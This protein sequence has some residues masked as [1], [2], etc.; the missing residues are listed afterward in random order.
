MHLVGF[1]IRIY[2][3]ARSPERQTQRT[4][5]VTRS[6]CRA[7]RRLTTVQICCTRGDVNSC[8]YPCNENQLN[9][10]FIL[11]LFRPSTS[12]GHICSPSSG[13]KL[14]IYSNW[15]VLCFSVDCLLDGLEWILKS[16][17]RTVPVAVYIQYTS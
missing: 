17:T 7:L 1:S 15:Y 10:L 6:V 2:H 11:S 14:Y 16:T 12:S 9:A 8:C 3:D 5:Y 4:V 13:G